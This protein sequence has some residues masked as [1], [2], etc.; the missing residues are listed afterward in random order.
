MT[1]AASEAQTVSYDSDD[2]DA[3]WDASSAALI[4]LAGGSITFAGTGATVDGS[5][6]TITAAGTYVVTGTLTDGQIV[7]ES[8]DDGIVHLVLN[9]ADITC[10]DNPA[11]Y[12]KSA[13]KTVVTLADGTENSL[14]DGAS[15]AVAETD[16]DAPS[17]T[18]FSKDDLTINGLGSLQVTANYNDGIT[19]NDDLKIVSGTITVEAVDDATPGQGQPRRESGHRHGDVGRRRHEGHQ[20]PGCHQG[21]RRNR[22]R[23][24][25]DQRGHRRHPGRDDTPRERR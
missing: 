23:H 17:A 14:T 15:Y 8:A 9:G 6:I 18:L 11:I 16:T 24:L 2:E 21:L 13:D 22:R 3:T 5:T 25:R 20:R 4:T 12:V 19:S 7:V 1:A 10:S